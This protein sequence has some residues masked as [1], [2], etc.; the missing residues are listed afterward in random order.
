MSSSLSVRSV[1]LCFCSVAGLALS[2]VVFAQT[3]YYAAYGTEYA[4]A[5]SL[6][7]DQVRPD[8][9]LTTSGGFVVWQDNATDGDGWG[10]SAQ[11]L[12]DTLS[13]TLSAFRVNAQGVGNQ[14][15]PRVAMLKNGGAVFAWQGGKPGAQHIYAR[16]LTPANTFVATND[17]LVSLSNTNA[18]S[19]TTNHTVTVVTN[20]VH[21]H[22]TYTTNVTTTIVTNTSGGAAGFQAN[23]A[24]A[25]LNDGNVV[26]VWASFNEAGSNSLLDVFG[27]LLSPTGQK[28]GAEFLVNQFTNYNQRTPAVATLAN[29]GFV[30]T[31]VSEQE[32]TAFNLGGVDNTNGTSPT[33]IGLPS[34]DVYARLYNSN[35]VAQTS[36]FLVNADSNPAAD[37]VVAAAT[38]GSFTVAWCARNLAESTN[39]WDIYARTFTNVIGGA[40]VYVNTHLYGDQY[41]PR[42][43]GIGEDYLIIWTS[44]GQD[45]SREGVFG[46][47]MHEGGS[48]LGGE[49]Q[50]NT[51]WQGQQMQPV[52]A[53]D[54][55]SQFLA[56][57][58][59]F[60]F[61]ASGMDLF[62]QRYLSTGAALPAIDS[63][64]VYAPFTLSNGVYQPQLR[65]AWPLLSGISVSNFEVYVDNATSPTG[66]TASNFWTMTAADGLTTNDTH[67]FQV[68]YVTTDGRRPSNLSPSVSG[69]TWSGLNWGG[70]PY[71]WMAEY[72]GGYVNGQYYTNNWPLPGS[73]VA[74][75]GPTLLQVFLSGGNPFISTTW[76]Q[77]ALTSTKEGLFLSWNTQPGKTYQVE[78]TTNFVTWSN[79]PSPY[80]SPRFASG[81][82]DS[83]PVGNGASGYYR[84]VLLR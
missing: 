31:W 66:L 16:F 35:G 64:Y 5:G 47:F 49:F 3:N 77:T 4:I 52:V 53:S 78:V 62:A 72:Y 50:V 65:V 23:P 73:T 81:T 14:E 17:L 21:N 40:V 8:A 59:G 69:K 36:E 82:S 46:R 24:L 80:D 74:A 56:V 25:V 84:V 12:D 20:T 28:I 45:G 79:L 27:Q 38:D 6:P 18:T 44:L 51:T 7:G 43:S 61:T 83:I 48:M 70:I 26:A 33:A 71:E 58:A 29:G 22:T 75:G 11:R 10:V 60:T 32:R 39:S 37:P 19:Y 67:Y 15:N 76:L 30:V 13:S 55:D 42:I 2:P 9:A 54:G 57:W 63:V 41:A 34:V 68:S 1:A